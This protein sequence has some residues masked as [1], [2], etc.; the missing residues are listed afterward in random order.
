MQSRFNETNTFYK[1][2]LFHQIVHVK[3]KKIE[4]FYFDISKGNILMLLLHGTFWLEVSVNFIFLN[5][6]MC[7]KLNHSIC[8]QMKHFSQPKTTLFNFDFLEKKIGCGVWEMVSGWITSRK[9]IPLLKST[10]ELCLKN[11]L[12][13]PLD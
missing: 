11:S 6:N 5:A 9:M 2:V 7:S 1:L 13:F 10:C 3:Q 8:G 4:N 12:F